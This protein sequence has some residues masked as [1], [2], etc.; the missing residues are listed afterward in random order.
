MAR[1]AKAEW[2]ALGV[3]VLLQ[4]LGRD[5]G[6]SLQLLIQ[7]GFKSSRLDKVDK[8]DEIGATAP[9]MP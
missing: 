9:V 7:S 4:W 5:L 3:T 6:R 8:L 1:S 2:G